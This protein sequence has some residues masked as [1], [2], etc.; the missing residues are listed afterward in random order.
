MMLLLAKQTTGRSAHQRT[1][2]TARVYSNKHDDSPLL[3][4]L[5]SEPFVVADAIAIGKGLN[6]RGLFFERATTPGQQMRMPL[7]NTLLVAAEPDASENYVGVHRSF[8]VPFA[9]V[10]SFSC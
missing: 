1:N 7:S 4:T 2:S 6:G 9:M 8:V 5:K 3:E 10:A